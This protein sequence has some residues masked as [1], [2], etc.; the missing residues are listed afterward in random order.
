MNGVAKRNEGGR[1]VRRSE[2]S[3]EWSRQVEPCAV[4]RSRP[5]NELAQRMSRKGNIRNSAAHSEWRLAPRRLPVNEASEW[6][7]RNNVP[8]LVRVDYATASMTL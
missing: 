8:L 1:A 4:E 2:C 6:T 5:V 7:E 3:S